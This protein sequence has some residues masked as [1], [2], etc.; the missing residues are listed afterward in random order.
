M[1]T[2]PQTNDVITGLKSFRLRYGDANGVWKGRN[3][4][5]TV[6]DKFTTGP[7]ARSIAKDIED[8]TSFV[9]DLVNL[10]NLNQPKAGQRLMS[11]PLYRLM[12][13]T[14]LPYIS[15]RMEQASRRIRKHFKKQVPLPVGATALYVVFYM[16]L[17]VAQYPELNKVSYSVA[18]PIRGVGS[19]TYQIRKIGEVGQ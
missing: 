19:T 18:I 2:R 10:D 4:D 6:T 9:S 15:R 17:N 7:D 12:L 13:F 11:D 14:N 5:G 3:T 16:K 8:K 1:P